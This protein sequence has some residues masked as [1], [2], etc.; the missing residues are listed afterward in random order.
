[1]L[2]GLLGNAMPELLD[3]IED[4]EKHLRCLRSI[5]AAWNNQDAPPANK[6]PEHG[7]ELR[8][9]AG[10]PIK[11]GTQHNANSIGAHQP[12]EHVR[13]IDELGIVF[14]ASSHGKIPKRVAIAAAGE[15]HNHEPTL[16]RS[17]VYVEPTLTATRPALGRLC[18]QPHHV[19][20][21]YSNLLRDCRLRETLAP[22]LRDST[23]IAVDLP[24]TPQG[25]ALGPH[26]S[27]SGTRPL[28]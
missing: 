1:L 23:A 9:T 12:H 22:K 21:S 6:F 14:P 25:L 20:R 2:C 16:A 11:I 17:R 10:K 27:Q 8:N 7:H 3:A 18:E 5:D 4:L 13:V 28:F 26:C 24:R 15:N 19:R